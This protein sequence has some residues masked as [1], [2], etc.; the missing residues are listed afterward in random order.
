MRE[1]AR[2]HGARIFQQRLLGYSGSGSAVVDEP[3]LSLFGPGAGVEFET[4]K[5]VLADGGR[6]GIRL[7]DVREEEELAMEKVEGAEWIPLSQWSEEWE[8]KITD[9]EECLVFF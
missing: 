5:S 3:L 6:K 7:I 2:P 9:P 8:Q 4:L 1:D